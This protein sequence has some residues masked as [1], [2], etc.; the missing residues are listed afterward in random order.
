MISEYGL[1]LGQLIVPA[2]AGILGVLVGGLIT[3]H[4]QR[5]ERQHNGIRRQLECFYG[6]LLAM[7]RQIRSKSELRVRLHKIADAAY[8]KRIASVRDDPQALQAV[9]KAR[10][11]QFDKVFEYSDEQLR[12]ELIPL[13]RK[14]LDHVTQYMWL[15]EPST[16]DHFDVL[17]E[18]VE[19]WNR[20]LAKTLPHEVLESIDHSEKDLDPFYEDLEMQTKKLRQELKK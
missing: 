7:R 3:A 9:E 5:R 16:L 20:F 18:F 6:P 4:S 17:V 14:M 1:G 2:A 11:A 10:G 15:A 13:Y 12:N 8:Q 19:I